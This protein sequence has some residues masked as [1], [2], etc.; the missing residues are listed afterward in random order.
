MASFKTDQERFWAGEFGTEY[1]ARNVGTNWVASNTA[2]FAKV[3]ARTDNVR[4]VLEL[5]ANI[6][7]NLLAIRNL[8]PE[9]SLTA[10][11][12]NE[13][14]AIELRKIPGMHV[15]VGS[16]LGFTVPRPSD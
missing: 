13:T 4:S 6:G 16:M 3:L 15:H 2:L 12:I 10:V 11:E 1:S 5:G 7:L 14:A 8:L 9:A